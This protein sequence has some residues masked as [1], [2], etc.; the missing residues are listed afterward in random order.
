ME[1]KEGE[2]EKKK[3]KEEGENEQLANIFKISTFMMVR[4]R[5]C[6]H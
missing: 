3:K 4:R 5:Q 2:K 6:Q 1:E